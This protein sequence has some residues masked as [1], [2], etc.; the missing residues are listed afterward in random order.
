M[1]SVQQKLSPFV[2][3]RGEMGPLL[4]MKFIREVDAAKLAGALTDGR[5]AGLARQALQ[6]EAEE[7]A[8][9]MELRNTNAFLTWPP[10]KALIQREWV[11]PLTMMEIKSL[12]DGLQQRPTETVSGFR[13]RVELAHI[14]EDLT[15]TA[16]VKDEAGYQTNV[17]RRVRRAYLS[18]LRQ[19]IR[20]AMVGVEPDTATLDEMERLAKNAELLQPRVAAS[21]QAMDCGPDVASPDMVSA[22][23]DA[24]FKKMN[25]SRGRGRGGGAGR[26]GA[27]RGGASGGSGFKGTCHRCGL[28]DSHMQRDCIVNLEKLERRRK[29][30]FAEEGGSRGGR[31][32]GGGQGGGSSYAAQ[33]G[34]REEDGESMASGPSGYSASAS[35]NWPE[36]C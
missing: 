11:R 1:S 12:M 5:T 24:V 8:V 25:A 29:G 26:G 19:N 6:G 27:G 32:R 20:S 30:K 15:L 23:V 22:V 28:I 2:G 36:N 16:E 9:V 18:G 13:I 35:Y 4:A 21:V 33:D 31:G 3:N 17:D 14:Q 10:L 7:W 34:G